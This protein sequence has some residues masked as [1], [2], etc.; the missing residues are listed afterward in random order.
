MSEKPFIQ[1]EYQVLYPEY[2]EVYDIERLLSAF[3]KQGW[4]LVA[5]SH[6]VYYLKRQKK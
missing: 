6:G 3:G 4:E 1:F 2:S 5:V